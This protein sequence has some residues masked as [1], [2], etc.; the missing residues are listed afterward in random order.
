MG[1]RPRRLA[2]ASCALLFLLGGLTQAQADQAARPL[3]LNP[4]TTHVSLRPFVRLFREDGSSMGIAQ[5]QAQAFLPAR[6][7]FTDARATYW[8]RFRYRTQGANRFFVF[9]GYKPSY[10]D[11]YVQRA[12]GSFVHRRSGG[13]VPFADRPLRDYGVIEFALP[14]APHSALAYL[15]VRSNEPSTA[16][17]I[18]SAATMTSADGAVMAVS[19]AICSV[20]TMLV[21]MSLV[22]FG[23]LRRAVYAFYSLYLLCQILYRLNDSGLAGAL[24]WPHAAF[25]WMRGDVMFDGATLIAAT[26]FARAFLDLRSY[27]RVLDSA[28]VVVALV[29]LG[30]LI[31]AAAN[32]P[33]RI[34]LVWDFAFV[35][36]PLWIVSSA[37]CWMRGHAR[38][39]YLLAAWSALMLGQLLLDVKNMGLAPG[40]FAVLFAFSYGPYFGLMLECMLITMLLSF[41]A[42]REYSKRLETTVAERTGQLREALR[43]AESANHELHAFSYA[44]AH[45]LRTPLRAISGFTNV[46][47]EDYAGALDEQGVRYVERITSSVTRMAEMI[48]ALLSLAVVSR[49]TLDPQEV[50][51]SAA[52]R[53]L[54]GELLQAYP[55][56]TPE[57][58]VADG[59]TAIGDR[60]LLGN[61]LQNLLGNALKFSSKQP[62]SRVEFGARTAEGSSVYFV[63]DNGVGFDMTYAHKIY[64]PFQRLHRA[65]EFQGTG[66]GLATAQR[67]VQRHG[68]TI[69]AESAPGHG[70]AFY[71]TLNALKRAE[72]QMAG[73][74]G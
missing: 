36:V 34:T 2:A 8:L 68:G 45:D 51:L 29:G 11:L 48:E 60:G 22:L 46:L 13:A 56:R 17:S 27:S 72:R 43:S 9:L 21:L 33:I 55:G 14:P 74:R 6:N 10:A 67:I 66:I 32:V 16:L 73:A 71:F 7:L 63:K 31:A 24:L 61:L 49:T 18:E 35:Y 20:L 1:M 57:L 42:Q 44:V 25:S 40:N 19:I 30:Y 59:V 50:N 5:A 23:M 26:L 52:A 62:R 47:A 4:S 39:K 3:V 15:R 65:D 58:V 41:D 69:W 54:L 70:A 53:E 12:D 38:A 64:G 37:W 28:N